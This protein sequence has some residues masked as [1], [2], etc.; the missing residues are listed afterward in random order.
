[1]RP[2][3]AE[4]IEGEAADPL[5]RQHADARPQLSFA[6]HVGVARPQDGTAITQLQR[7]NKFTFSGIALDRNPITDSKIPMAAA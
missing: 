4:I 5:P 3:H 1:M 2:E 6:G 7:N